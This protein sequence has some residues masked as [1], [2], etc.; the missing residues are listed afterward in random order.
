MSNNPTGS[1]L[2]VETCDVRISYRDHL[3]AIAEK[4]K[5]IEGLRAAGENLLAA[6][7]V[8]CTSNGWDKDHYIQART[9][10]KLTGGAK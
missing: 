6:W 9:M 5:R 8:V 3:A 10:R 4:D 1:A 7:D 2:V